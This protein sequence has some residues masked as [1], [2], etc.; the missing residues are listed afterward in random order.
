MRVA[1]DTHIEREE[2]YVFSLAVRALDASAFKAIGREMATRRGVASEV[3]PR[4]R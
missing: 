1:Y 2:T 4:K 3:L